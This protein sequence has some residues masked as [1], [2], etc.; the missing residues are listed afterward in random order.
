MA[1]SLSV[2]NVGALP[3]F[4]TS[5]SASIIDVTLASDSL[6]ALLDGWQVADE[7]FCSDHRLI[8]FRLQI[9]PPSLAPVKNYQRTDW[10]Q[11]VMSLQHK[12]SSWK[13]PRWWTKQT[14][15]AEAASLAL[16]ITT[17]VDANT[18][19]FASSVG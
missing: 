4:S 11:T 13:A 10:C 16:L 17:T 5:R 7:D 18:P 14:L 8:T 2:M 6:V 12:C 9:A 15:D 3:T 1:N 19:A